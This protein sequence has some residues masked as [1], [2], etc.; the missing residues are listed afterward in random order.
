MKLC[1]ERGEESS[2]QEKRNLPLTSEMTTMRQAASASFHSPPKTAGAHVFLT[3]AQCL[4][5]QIF[6]NE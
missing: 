1:S 5:Q 4:A 3:P 6:L 2:H